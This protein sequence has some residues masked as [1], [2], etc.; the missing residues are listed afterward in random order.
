MGQEKLWLVALQHWSNIQP[1][2]GASKYMRHI[3]LPHP[4]P[5]LPTPRS[6]PQRNID[7]CVTVERFAWDFRNREQLLCEVC[8]IASSCIH[9]N[10]TR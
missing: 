5:T 7:R 4:P 6:H 8:R 2:A 1:L 3:H 9:V 10:F